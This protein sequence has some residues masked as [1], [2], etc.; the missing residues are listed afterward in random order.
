MVPYYYPYLAA[1]ETKTERPN[2]LPKVR[3]LISG[4]SW[5]QTSH[6]ALKSVHQPWHPVASGWEN[7]PNHWTTVSFNLL[8]ET[9]SGVSYVDASVTSS[10]EIWHVIQRCAWEGIW[11]DF[12]CSGSHMVIHQSALFDRELIS[13][14]RKQTSIYVGCAW[15]IKQSQ[16][17]FLSMSLLWQEGQCEAL[18][19]ECRCWHSRCML[20]CMIN[21]LPVSIRPACQFLDVSKSSFDPSIFIQ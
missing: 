16:W 13:Q 11:C 21:T 5:L 10:L 19:A 18:W 17:Q 12:Q 4:R 20:F 6:Q 8:C 1:E 7:S 3:E 14:V 9:G 2:N 15:K